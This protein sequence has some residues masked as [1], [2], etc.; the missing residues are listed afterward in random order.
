MELWEALNMLKTLEGNEIKS[1]MDFHV[2]IAGTLG[3]SRHYGKN[4]EALW[5]VIAPRCGAASDLGLASLG[6]ISHNAGG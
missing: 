5:D 2:A 4:L 3:F 1:E 6:G